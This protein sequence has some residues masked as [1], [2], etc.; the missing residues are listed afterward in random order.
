MPAIARANDVL[1]LSPMFAAIVCFIW[2]WL[3]G[4]GDIMAFYVICVFSGMAMGADVALLPSLFADALADK[5]ESSATGF[6]LWNLTS[7]FTMALAAGITLPVLVFSGY[8]A[9]ASNTQHALA[10]LSIS[11]ALLP[12]AFKAIAA[13][14]LY[15]SPLDR[16]R[17]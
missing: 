11:Y 12:C 4:R 1:C 5:R 14:L 16:K 6:G 15:I 8:H 13:G 17:V 2:A 9:A 3:L 10:W 7:K